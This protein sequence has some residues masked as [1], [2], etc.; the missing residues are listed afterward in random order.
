MMSLLYLNKIKI[1]FVA[2][3]VMVNVEDGRG[4]VDKSF[5]LMGGVV[6]MGL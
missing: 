5:G 3:V 6:G 1:L 2:V 4:F